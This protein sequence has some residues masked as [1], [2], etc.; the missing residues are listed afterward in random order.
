MYRKSTHNYSI[1]VYI[2]YET[3]DIP[4]TR[5]PFYFYSV[6]VSLPT[7]P[8]LR[9]KKHKKVWLA[10]V[11]VLF[12]LPHFLGFLK[13]RRLRCPSFQKS[14]VLANAVLVLAKIIVV[15]VYTPSPSAVFFWWLLL[16][17]SAASV[18]AQWGCLYHLRSTMP[19]PRYAT[20]RCTV[21][22]ALVT[23]AYISNHRT[24]SVS[25]AEFEERCGRRLFNPTVSSC[26][27]S[28][29]PKKS[30]GVIHLSSPGG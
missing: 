25:Q 3:C 22:L 18:V 2:S 14:F 27:I 5:A 9:S 15:I 23:L 4:V 24:R 12:L 20:K 28:S 21:E 26:C 13:R 7:S 16:A 1:T 6:N 11:R 19:T 30:G 29:L 17:L 8:R 10:I